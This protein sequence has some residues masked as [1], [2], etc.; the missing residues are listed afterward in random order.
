MIEWEWA[1]EFQRSNALVAILGKALGLS[2]EE[3]NEGF[4]E[5]ALL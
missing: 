1:T 5:A 4:K 2:D 3:V